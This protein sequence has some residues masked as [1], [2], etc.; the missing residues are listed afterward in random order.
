MTSAAPTPRPARTEELAPALR[1]VFQDVAPG[2]RDGRVAN[3]LRLLGRG[4]I[5]PEGFFVLPGPDGPLAALVCVPVPGASA[6]V[7]PP[8]AVAD[9]RRK[10]RE[11]LLVRHVRHWLQGRGVKLAQALLAPEEAHLASPL[12]RNGFAH[13]TDLWYLR[14]DLQLPGHWLSAPARCQLETYGPASAAEFQLALSRTYE[15]SRDC[16]EVNGVR[17]MEEVI[18]GHQSQGL[19][20]PE[21]WWLARA[22][23][24]AA[25]V[26]LLTEMPESGDWEVAY[27]GVV[28]EARR[29]GLGRELV[30]HAL[31]EAR[32]A[33]V[34]RLTLSVD[35]RNQPAWALYRG[36]GFE[37]YDRRAV[38]LAV[39]R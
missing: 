13:V 34:A 32:A 21:R 2:E 38:F 22:D 12:V 31:V 36:L 8:A 6:L 35:T 9:S 30:L 11:D 25:A 5:D 24:R 33:G 14:H 27:V 18:R 3:A 10:E 20:D 4:E 39:W 16:P 26:L 23:G 7:W 29:R 17:S 28:P 15:D 37:P 19:Y 1:L